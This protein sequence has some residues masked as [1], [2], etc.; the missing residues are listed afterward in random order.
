MEE[1]LDTYFNYK[2]LKKNLKRDVWE[3]SFS[4]INNKYEETG[5]D[6]PFKYFIISLCM[7]IVC[8]FYSIP[9]ILQN[10]AIG[11]KDMSIYAS[12]DELAQRRI[13]MASLDYGINYDDKAITPTKLNIQEKKQNALNILR[14]ELAKNNNILVGHIIDTRFPSM[15]EEELLTY[16]NTGKRKKP[17]MVQRITFGNNL[18]QAIKVLFSHSVKHRKI[19]NESNTY[20]VFEEETV[21]DLEKRIQDLFMVNVKIKLT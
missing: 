21:V 16:I 20:L 5:A 3:R 8:I 2:M 17:L 14:E 11:K 1:F 10:I 13:R 6:Q 19:K 15:S 12:P 7:T 4:I 9:Y 18:N